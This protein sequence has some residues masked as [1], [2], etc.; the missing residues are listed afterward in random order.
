MLVLD[1][2]AYYEGICYYDISISIIPKIIYY[3][4]IE[5][6]IRYRTFGLIFS[7][8]Y[9]II[10]KEHSHWMTQEGNTQKLQF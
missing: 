1:L 9:T 2:D 7:I 5:N 3:E 8:Y 6:R 10:L 4:Y